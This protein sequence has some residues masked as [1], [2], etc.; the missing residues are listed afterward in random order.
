M[1][2]PQ[3]SAPFG[4][5]LR[6]HRLTAGLTQEALAERAGLS[7][8]AVSE[9]ERGGRRGPRRETVALLAASP[10]ATAPSAW[11]ARG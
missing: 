8:R 5:L 3:D 4:R 11:R 1:S 6:E 2:V 10:A 9:L 7:T